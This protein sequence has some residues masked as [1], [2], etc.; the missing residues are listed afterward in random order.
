MPTTPDMNAYF[1]VDGGSVLQFCEDWRR[2]V[3]EAYDA[4]A[5]LAEKYGSS[6]YVTITPSGAFAGLH[7]VEPV[8]AGWEKTSI[9]KGDVQILKPADGPEGAAVQ[10][11]I[12]ALPRLPKTG[13]IDDFLNLPKWVIG[14]A[15]DGRI[16]QE[17]IHNN[18][19]NRVD[20]AWGAKDGTLLLRMPD[21]DVVIAAIS[22]RHPGIRIDQGHWAPPKGLTRITRAEFEAIYAEDAEREDEALAKAVTSEAGARRNRMRA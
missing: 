9:L 2:Y 12:D 7:V 1:R 18:L 16:V 6:G 21:P 19:A 20:M 11:E 15:T 5:A 14:T 3:H 22:D 10:A 17:P 13:E 4:M 8:P